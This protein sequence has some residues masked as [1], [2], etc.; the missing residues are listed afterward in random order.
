[1]LYK[2]MVE[3]MRSLGVEPVPTTGT[4]FDPAI[5]DG[6]MREPSNEHP[7]GTV[8]QEFRK[9]FAIGGKLLRPAMVKVSYTEDG[10]IASSEE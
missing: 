2:Q 7:D 3:L 10:P 8:L 6:I 1:S 5:H 9:G 4:P